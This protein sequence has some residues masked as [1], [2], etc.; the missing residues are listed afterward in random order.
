MIKKIYDAMAAGLRR[1]KDRG[2]I[3]FMQL[4]DY[5]QLHSMHFENL[6]LDFKRLGLNNTDYT[7]DSEDKLGRGFL[8]AGQEIYKKYHST[9]KKEVVSNIL[10]LLHL[11]RVIIHFLPEGEIRLRGLQ[12][13]ARYQAFI[14]AEYQSLFEKLNNLETNKGFGAEDVAVVRNELDFML[15]S[16]A[17]GYINTPLRETARQNI[18]IYAFWMGLLQYFV[19]FLLIQ[20]YDL[21]ATI[22]IPISSLFVPFL[23]SIGACFAIKQKVE[24]M[25]ET[26]DKYRNVLLLNSSLMG[27]LFGLFRGAVAAVL[28]NMVLVSQFIQGEIFPEFQKSS[29]ASP[30]GLNEAFGFL[31]HLDQYKASEIAKI[32]IWSL[33]AGYSERLIP[34]TIKKLSD[35]QSNSMQLATTQTLNTGTSSPKPAESTK[36]SPDSTLIPSLPNSATS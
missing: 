23:G 27:I 8:I 17:R 31:L 13:T 36:S 15:Y 24:A 14:G 33:V 16:L 2:M 29:D 35:S 7:I 4:I 20:F 10:N 25:P 12:I 28:L 30:S 18:W 1:P 3:R 5:N 34:D 21:F 32:L 11:E 26:V 19:L 6:L 22:D 9:E